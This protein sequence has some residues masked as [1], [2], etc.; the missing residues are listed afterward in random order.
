MILSD[1][2]FFGRKQE[3]KKLVV[4]ILLGKHT[5]IIGKRG[6]GKTTL[7][8]H[9]ISIIKGSTH[10]IDISPTALAEEFKDIRLAHKL[11]SAWKG[12][13][14]LIKVNLN[15]TK[16]TIFNEIIESLYAENDLVTDELIRINSDGTISIQVKNAPIIIKSIT[17]KNYIF[18]FDD[19][20]LATGQMIEFIIDLMP[21]ATII[22]TTSELKHEKKFKHL[23]SF[24]EKIQLKELEKETTEKL[25]N[26][27]IETYITEIDTKTKEFLKNEILRISKGNPTIIKSALQQAKSQ[28]LIRDEDIKKL[29]TLEESEYINLGPFFALLLGSVTVIKILQIGLENRETY[30]LLSIFSFLSYLTIRIFRYFFLFRPQRKK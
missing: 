2:K 27:L 22:A 24:F 7:I 8:E 10:R 21:H 4:N 5:L 30:I 29:R 15:K 9:A 18:L 13:I 1:Q 26:Y 12:E 20:D 28:K 23:Y 14:K 3:L 11:K 6:I 25:T 16:S 17:G 19:L